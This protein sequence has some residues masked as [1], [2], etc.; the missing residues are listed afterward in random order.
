MVFRRVV[1]MVATILQAFS[2]W[3]ARG[4]YLLLGCYN[5]FVETVAKV[6]VLLALAV[7]RYT[8]VSARN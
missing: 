4:V 2:E 8:L 3:N 7:Y 6:Q 1:L 5:S